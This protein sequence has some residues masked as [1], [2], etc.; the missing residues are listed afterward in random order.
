MGILS[1][2]DLRRAILNKKKLT[3][4]ISKIYNSN[5]FYLFENSYDLEN[6]K[7]S[8]GVVSVVTYLD[9]PGRNDVGPVFDGDPIFPKNKVDLVAYC[10]YY[11]I[12]VPAIV[13]SNNVI[14]FQFHPEKSGKN[15]LE[16]LKNTIEEAYV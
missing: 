15:G 2:G 4:N 11:D 6:V 13:K 3:E 9:I 1:D 8:E 12:H 16:I 14:G 7:K 5:S 10:K